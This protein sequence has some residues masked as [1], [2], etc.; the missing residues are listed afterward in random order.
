MQ[1]KAK[2]HK[3]LPNGRAELVVQRQSACSGDC[4]SC[5]GCG[6]VQQTLLLTAKNAIGAAEG[7]LVYVETATGLVLKAAALVYLL[8]LILFL[9]G[10]FMAIS[11][12]GWAY[13]VGIAGFLLGLLPATLFDRALRKRPPNY[14]IV[15]FVN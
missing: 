4:G 12:G 10:Y 9:V 3:L 5:G 7:D 13:A 1:Q 6:A 14:V 15:G 2:V 8:P 11:L